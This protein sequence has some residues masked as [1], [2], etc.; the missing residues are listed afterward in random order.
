MF[1]VTELQDGSTLVE[2]TDSKGVEGQCILHSHAW[3]AYQHYLSQ[4]AA[5][6]EFDKT[7]EEFFAPLTAA[8]DKLVEETTN[9]WQ[10]LTVG[11]DVEGVEAQKFVLDSDG[12]I[13]RMLAETDGAQLRWV[14]NVLVA[15]K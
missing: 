6:E 13:L 4:T 1:E 10:I 12:I 11:E 9:P 7:V 8:A 5:M 3:S 15:V 14:N 2:G